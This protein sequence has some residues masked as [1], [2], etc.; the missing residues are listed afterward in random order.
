MKLSLTLALGLV[1]LA[2]ATPVI[3]EVD[4]AD[5]NNVEKRFFNNWPKKPTNKPSIPK[6]PKPTF[7]AWPH[8]PQFGNSTTT[9]VPKTTSKTTS[10][11]T[12][13]TTAKTTSKLTP[14]KTATPTKPTPTTPTPTSPEAA[15]SAIASGIQDL[16]QD[17]YN[18]VNNIISSIDKDFSSI[19]GGFSF[20]KR[21]G[22]LDA[23]IE[24]RD[25]LPALEARSFNETEVE[26]ALSTLVTNV[27]G[28]LLTL[29]NNTNVSLAQSL[30]AALQI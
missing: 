26:E 19:F 12:A 14:T 7:P 30:L 21:D 1:T 18:D 17:I 27:F 29:T 8:W 25:E 23:G 20:F 22:E 9:S 4:A 2:A 15:V 6:Q 13:K 10:K 11:T 5:N 28:H 16:L 3:N 24:A